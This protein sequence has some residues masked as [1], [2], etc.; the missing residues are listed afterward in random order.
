MKAPFRGEE[1]ERPA[2]HLRCALG[3][4]KAPLAQDVETEKPCGGGQTLAIDSLSFPPHRSTHRRQSHLPVAPLLHLLPIASDPIVEA[5]IELRAVAASYRAPLP[6]GAGENAQD[7][8]EEIEPLTLE[9]V[10]P[11]LPSPPL[12]QTSAVVCLS[13]PPQSPGPRR[14]VFQGVAEE[15]SCLLPTHGLIVWISSS[16]IQRSLTTD[17]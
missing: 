3:V 7:V 12:F 15:T 5:G 16:P 9:D 14:F 8:A 1:M 17:D 11:S 4:E 2:C 6:G 13:P 10:S